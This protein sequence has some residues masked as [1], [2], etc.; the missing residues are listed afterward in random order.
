MLGRRRIDVRVEVAPGCDLHQVVELLEGAA[1]ADERIR[2]EPRP[3]LELAEIAKDKLVL[4]LRPW[5][6][7]SDQADVSTALLIRARA[8]MA[9][10]GVEH[11]IAIVN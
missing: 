4:H 8:A 1:L 9:G 7:A 11:A 5:T 6:D 3:R 10:T 2:T